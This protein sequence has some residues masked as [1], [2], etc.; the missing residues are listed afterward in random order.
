MNTMTETEHLIDAL[1]LTDDE[2]RAVR[3]LG[4]A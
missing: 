2:R 3:G 4:T 1:T